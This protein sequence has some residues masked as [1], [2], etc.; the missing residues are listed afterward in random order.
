MTYILCVRTPNIST[1]APC[2]CVRAVCFAISC[3]VHNVV[4]L[5]GTLKHTLTASDIDNV[6]DVL[7]TLQWKEEISFVRRVPYWS[8]TG[9]SVQCVAPF[10]SFTNPSDEMTNVS[11]GPSAAGTVEVV[12]SKLRS[13]VWLCF[14]ERE[15]EREEMK[16]FRHK[17]NSKLNQDI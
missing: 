7:T 2:L 16:I 1:S 13:L 14:L 3:T 12:Y 6:S 10:I 4:T 11:I 9:W 8:A 5:R 17:P 15:R